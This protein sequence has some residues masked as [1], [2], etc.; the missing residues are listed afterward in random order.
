MF[1]VLK[2]MKTI[3][4][5]SV[6]AG[7]HSGLAVDIHEYFKDEK[8]YRD[9]HKVLGRFARSGRHQELAHT[10]LLFMKALKEG[11][12]WRFPRNHPPLRGTVA[13]QSQGIF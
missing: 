12:C 3:T 8:R 5:Q 9:W 11:S 6:E 7:V 10:F 1:T 13:T 4:E 2:G